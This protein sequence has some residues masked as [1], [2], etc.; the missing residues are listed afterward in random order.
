MGLFSGISKVIG[1]VSD[2]IAPVTGLMTG[3]PWLGGALGAG[4]DYFSS[5]QANDQNRD[6]ALMQM[7]F[8][9]RMSS[10]AYQRAV[11][12]ARA[13]GLSPMLTA[14]QGGA[15]TPAGSTATMSPA[16]MRL[17]QNLALSRQS[18][19]IANVQANTALAASQARG[20]A[21]RNR[22]FATQL[23]EAKNK[24]DIS[25][26]PYLGQAWSFV[27]RAASTIGKVF[28]AGSSAKS[29]LMDDPYY[30]PY[31]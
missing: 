24:E 5:A 16:T 28:G 18:A 13:A 15:S 30:S 4:L 10:T 26:T 6:L 25:N 3:N 17:A 1:K 29:M 7:D 21:I 27:D 14:G 23:P 2:F 12:D 9:N 19:D 20:V 22:L 11:A 31:K 8:Q